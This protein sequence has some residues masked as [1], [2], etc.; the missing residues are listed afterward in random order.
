MDSSREHTRTF[1]DITK[2]T[3]T[4]SIKAHNKSVNAWPTVKARASNDKKEDVLST[5]PNRAHNKS[6]NAWP[7]VTSRTYSGS[8]GTSS[9]RNENEAP[10][11]TS[12]NAHDR[13]MSAWPLVKSKTY[14]GA[15]DTSFNEDKEKSYASERKSRYLDLRMPKSNESGSILSYTNV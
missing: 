6:V 7:S 10:S 14:P 2:K 5:I 1:A 8:T 11:M 4:M 3:S 9:S 13:P 12:T 15:T